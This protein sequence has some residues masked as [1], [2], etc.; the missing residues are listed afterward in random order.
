MSEIVINYHVTEKCNYICHHCFAKYDV[1][2]IHVKE[3]HH[4]LEKVEKVL[5]STYNFFKKDLLNKKIRLNFA[6]GEPLILKNFQGIINIAKK[7]GFEE[8]SLITNGSILT[9]KFIDDHIKSFSMI[10]ISIDSF[11]YESN[12]KIGRSTNK[13]VI[14]DIADLIEK[15]AYCK[16]INKDLNIKINTVVNK[17]NHKELMGREISKINPDKWKIFKVIPFNNVK[18]V[19]DKEFSIFIE[20]NKNNTLVPIYAEYTGDMEDSYIMI[21][22]LGRFYQNSNQSTGYEYSQPIYKTG[23]KNSFNEI[24]FDENKFKKRYIPI[25]REKVKCL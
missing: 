4:D 17:I 16:Y 8:L 7:I 5:R 18:T 25:N 20:N 9:K 19:T 2:N 11:D 13:K 23:V 1:E 22:P 6:G 12:V 15:I 3:M 21:D 10:G 24:N 14:L